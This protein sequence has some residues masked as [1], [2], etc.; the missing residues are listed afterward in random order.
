MNIP[1]I[2][3]VYCHL[4]AFFSPLHHL[5]S[6][7]SMTSLLQFLSMKLETVNSRMNLTPTIAG[8]HPND[9]SLSMLF[10]FVNTLNLSISH[11]RPVDSKIQPFVVGKPIGYN[12]AGRW[13]HSVKN[14]MPFF[15]TA[16]VV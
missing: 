12:I 5:T 10:L 16:K 11:E 15:L 9:V 8:F 7:L 3:Y 13:P 1:F 2:L 4:L 14:R 6:A